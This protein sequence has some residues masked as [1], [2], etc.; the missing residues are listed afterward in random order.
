MYYRY[1]ELIEEIMKPIL[2]ALLAAGLFSTPAQALS[3]IV[4][5]AYHFAVYWP[6]KV[7]TMAVAVPTGSLLI[8]NKV[9]DLNL[10]YKTK[11]TK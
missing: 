5:K 2:F 6:V 1:M 11:E 10:E 4:Y 8:L 9:V 7:I 3:P